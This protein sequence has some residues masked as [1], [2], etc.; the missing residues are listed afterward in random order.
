MSAQA[1]GLVPA[2]LRTTRTG[3]K[4]ETGSTSERMSRGAQASMDRW[5][6]HAVSCQE[7]EKSALSRSNR[8]DCKEVSPSRHRP[9]Q[10]LRLSD[11]VPG[12]RI[13][14]KNSHSNRSHRPGGD[15]LKTWRGSRQNRHL[16]VVVNCKRL[17]GLR[18]TRCR[19]YRR[20]LPLWHIGTGELTNPKIP[21]STP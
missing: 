3:V 1:K 15:H 11:G 8:R 19:F 12:W 2:P 5:P 10:I 14:A 20:S 17:Q 21:V 9:L 18:G 6:G 13:A 7:V 16:V 4:C